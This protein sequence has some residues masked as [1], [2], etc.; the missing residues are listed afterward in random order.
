MDAR[1][2]FLREEP[3]PQS[4]ATNFPRAHLDLLI[5]FRAYFSYFFMVLFKMDLLTLHIGIHTDRISR[6][7]FFANT[8]ARNCC[9]KHYAL[10]LETFQHDDVVPKSHI[11]CAE[12]SSRHC[13]RSIRD[14][15]GTLT[16]VIIQLDRAI[17]GASTSI[18][19]KLNSRTNSMR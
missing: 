12:Q 1:T 10:V 11:S 9:E 4:I 2:F 18:A 3:Q 13:A 15:Q 17:R 8:H 5:F 16:R 19:S 6:M 14:W 7:N